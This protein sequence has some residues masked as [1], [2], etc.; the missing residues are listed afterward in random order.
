MKFL[1]HFGQ[2]W[3]HLTAHRTWVRTS[4]WLCPDASGAGKCKPWADISQVTLEGGTEIF[5]WGANHHILR[6]EGA[7]E[8]MGGRNLGCHLQKDGS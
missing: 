1:K 7:L 5:L 8:E 3:T 2:E 4:P 6:K